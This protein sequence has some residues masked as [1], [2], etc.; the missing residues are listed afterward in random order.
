MQAEGWARRLR[1]ASWY[2]ELRNLGGALRAPRRE[3]SR[4]LIVG[5]PEDQPWHLTAHL[6]ML[7]QFRQL[8]ELYPTLV[9]SELIA[10]HP[11]DAI[12]VVSELAVPEGIL[13][14][15]QDARTQGSTV[16]GL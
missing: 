12:L 5:H 11:E 14:Q 13:E 10:S 6:E 2:D 1:G 3:S 8:P 9:R 7:A 4:L 15:V 16:F